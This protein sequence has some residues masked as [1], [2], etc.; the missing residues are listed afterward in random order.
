MPDEKA[1]GG[2]WEVGA[3]YIHS[4]HHGKLVQ[5]RP[6]A[7]FASKELQRSSP[8]MDTSLPS[9]RQ[10]CINIFYVMNREAWS[11]KYLKGNK[12]LCRCG[13]YAQAVAIYATGLV[14][15]RL[16]FQRQAMAPRCPGLAFG[17]V[18]ISTVANQEIVTLVADHTSMQPRER[19]GSE[20]QYTAN[21]T[22]TEIFILDLLNWVTLLVCVHARPGISC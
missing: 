6:N 9:C 4:L 17:N 18:P 20:N 13:H 12:E 16:V 1:R 14:P 3:R 2:Y 8:N 15:N 19:T 22:Y 10:R 21:Q 7:F 5:G 11:V